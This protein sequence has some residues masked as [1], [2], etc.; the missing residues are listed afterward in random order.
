M[1]TIIEAGEGLSAVLE[2]NGGP[3]AVLG[4]REG[5][6]LGADLGD[7]EDLGADLGTAEGVGGGSEV[8]PNLLAPGAF[9][10]G[11]EEG[12]HGMMIVWGE[13]HSTRAGPPLSDTPPDLKGGAVLVVPTE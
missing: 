11:L 3:G 12:T 4:A 5:E 2:T 9:L 1:G 7:S 10:L 6:D 13:A 8:T